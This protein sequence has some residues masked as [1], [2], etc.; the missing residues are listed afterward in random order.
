MS[1]SKEEDEECEG[2]SEEAPGGGKSDISPDDYQTAQE[3]ELT[4]WDDFHTPCATPSAMLEAS[5]DEYETSREEVETSVEG[6]DT[7]GYETAFEVEQ[8]TDPS[9]SLQL[10][11]KYIS[12]CTVFF[13]AFS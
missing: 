13:P 11:L 12:I 3:D 1:L 9:L 5:H 7:E 4:S 10:A 2:E 8:L 6:C